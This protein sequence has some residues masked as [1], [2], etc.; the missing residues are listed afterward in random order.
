M[1]G[2]IENRTPLNADLVYHVNAIRDN[3]MKMLMKLYAKDKNCIPRHYSLGWFGG[4]NTL[5]HVA[6]YF[7]RH[8]IALKLIDLG[9]DIEAKTGAG[10]TPLMVTCT[11]GYSQ[12]AIDLLER[13]ADIQ[14]KENNHRSVGDLMHSS[15]IKDIE[16]YYNETDRIR[17][18]AAQK[19][20]AAQRAKEEEEERLRLEEEEKAA[21]EELQKVEKEK[22]RIKA[23]FDAADE[24]G[25]GTLDSSEL[26]KVCADLGLELDDDEL[27][28]ALAILDE[29]GDGDISFEEF[30][31]WWL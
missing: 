30:C 23:R 13:G 25:G 10:Y 17:E 6:C 9:C 19:A 22:V 16:Y 26:K 27:E 8:E 7:N 18:E 3:D 28:T 14:A 15:I 11:C 21:Q 4:K 12:L 1:P 31:D 24:D 5:L 2:I 20:A 29:N